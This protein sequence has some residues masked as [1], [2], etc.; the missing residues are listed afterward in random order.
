MKNAQRP[1]REGKVYRYIIYLHYKK[2]MATYNVSAPQPFNHAKFRNFFLKKCLKTRAKRIKFAVSK[3]TE[4]HV[5]Q[6]ENQKCFG[7]YTTGPP[8]TADGSGGRS[9]GEALWRDNK[10]EGGRERR[11]EG[12][13]GRGR[14]S[15]R[16]GRIGGIGPHSEILVLPMNAP[17]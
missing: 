5:R 15:G 11:K 3:C 9:Q 8:R 13:A 7:G 17:D 6:C 2:L 16:V 4:A 12:E 10:E 1:R 14:E